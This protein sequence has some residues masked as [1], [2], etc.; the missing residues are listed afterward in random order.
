VRIRIQHRDQQL[1]LER[2][3]QSESLLWVA[4]LPAANDVT[5]LDLFREVTVPTGEYETSPEG[6]AIAFAGAFPVD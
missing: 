6:L 4:I 2:I 3:W 5:G 1:Y